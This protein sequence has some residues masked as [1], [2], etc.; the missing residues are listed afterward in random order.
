V[1][2]Y[3]DSS[4]LVKLVVEESE[5]EAARVYL[6]GD[7]TVV[8]SRVGLIESFRAVRRSDTEG[9]A[10]W[11]ELV[12]N[13]S[14]RELDPVIADRAASLEPAGLRTLD[15]IHLATALEMRG[16]I[17]AFLTYDARLAEAA[18]AHRLPVVSPA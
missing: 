13:I 3:A 5:S 2:V 10:P 16:E 1:L 12:A 4:A 17:D 8:V 7:V 6:S 9:P 11:A 15:A 18:R 14:V